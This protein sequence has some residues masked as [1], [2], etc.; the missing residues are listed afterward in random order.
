MNTAKNN[1]TDSNYCEKCN[2]F[3]YFLVLAQGGLSRIDKGIQ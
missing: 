1:S 2:I 3:V